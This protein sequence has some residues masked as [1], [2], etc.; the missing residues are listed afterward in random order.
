MTRSK[1]VSMNK[2]EKRIGEGKQ[3]L[4]IETEIDPMVEPLSEIEEDVKA[5]DDQQK[6]IPIIVSEK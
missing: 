4:V 6:E 2:G 5:E 1:M 3:Q